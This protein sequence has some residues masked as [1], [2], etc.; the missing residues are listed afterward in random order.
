MLGKQTSMRK[1]D[2]PFLVIHGERD[3]VVP[4]IQAEN[5]IARA[6]EIGVSFELKKIL[7]AGHGVRLNNTFE[8]ESFNDI[9]L[10]FLKK[11]L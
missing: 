2:P 6:K 7:G 11:H 5:L 4:Y 9:I 10:K 1:G 8:G 3:S